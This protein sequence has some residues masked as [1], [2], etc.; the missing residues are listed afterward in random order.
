[1][2]QRELRAISAGVDDAPGSAALRARV[3]G[4]ERLALT[5]RD[6]IGSGD[7]ERVATTS[8]AVGDELT[9]STR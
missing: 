6:A 2:G 3:R 5:V 9:G 4:L 7:F 8:A 1:M